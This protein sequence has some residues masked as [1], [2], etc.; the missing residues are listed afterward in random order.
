MNVPCLYSLA[1][2]RPGR[3]L[4]HCGRILTIGAFAC[5]RELQF[6]YDFPS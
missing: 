1:E 6:I 4:L 5:E 2:D 3:G